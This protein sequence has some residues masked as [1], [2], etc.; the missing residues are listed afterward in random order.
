MARVKPN[1]I[2]DRLAAKAF[3]RL[4]PISMLF[5]ITKECNLRCKHCYV[6]KKPGRREL[7]T[8]EIF[9]I[10]DEFHAE[11]GFFLSLTGGEATLHPDFLRILEHAR[12]LNLLSQVL[13]N[14]T[15]IDEALADAIDRLGVYYVGLS[16][17]GARPET[18][19]AITRVPGSFERTIRAAQLL[20][21]RRVCVNLKFIVMKQNVMEFDAVT[22][23]ARRLRIKYKFDATITPRNDRSRGPLSLRVDSTCLENLLSSAFKVVKGSVPR[24][25]PGRSFKCHAAHSLCSVTAYGELLPCVALPISAGDLTRKSF[26]ELWKQAK[27]FRRIREATIED[28]KECSECKLRRFCRRCPGT[29]YLEH[30]D[31]F[32]P[33]RFACLEAEVMAKLFERSQGA[34]PS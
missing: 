25:D 13:S 3:E 20:K 27:V 18:H 8:D 29:A 2:L 1:R 33:S 14:G 7:H 28:L 11:G 21:K 17:Y 16:I 19:D 23:L 5:E 31:M 22:A 30:G 34:F 6:V 12:N 32:K 24:E 10:I 9:R 15:L 4:Q 26:A